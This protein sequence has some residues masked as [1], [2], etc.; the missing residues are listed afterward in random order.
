V[1][2]WEETL[3]WRCDLCGH[4]LMSNRPNVIGA[5]QGSKMCTWRQRRNELYDAGG[6]PTR[7]FGRFLLHSG[8]PILLLGRGFTQDK[9]EMW[10]P[11]WGV[12]ICA[13][14]SMDYFRPRSTHRREVERLLRHLMRDENEQHAVMSLARLGGARAVAHAFHLHDYTQTS[15]EMKFVQYSPSIKMAG[16]GWQPAAPGSVVAQ[17]SG[18]D[19]FNDPLWWLN[20]ED[21]QR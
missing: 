18:D 19:F 3:A 17:V 2:V 15:F 5:H 11:V 8:L 12:V 7:S 14:I 20:P 4:R 9:K 16:S 6:A 21:S 13:S 1:S 10:A